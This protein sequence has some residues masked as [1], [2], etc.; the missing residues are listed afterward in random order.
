MLG[1]F[2]PGWIG[3]RWE[4]IVKR[5]QYF[6]RFAV[7][8]GV[9]GLAFAAAPPA[10]ASGWQISISP[11][12]GL[13]D[14]QLVL[15][16]GTGFTEHP[17]TQFVVDWAITE[18]N[19]TVLSQPLDPQLV[20]N[21]CDVTTE[22]FVFVHADAAG[23]VSGTFRVSTTFTPLGGGAVPVD[24]TQTQ[25]ALII[26][27]LTDAGFVGAAAP[28][29]FAPAPTCPRGDRGGHGYGDKNHCHRFRGRSTPT[30]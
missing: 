12:T 14:G 22:P 11:S 24:C 21:N 30:Q 29:S 19:S 1:W 25:C 9:V 15:V 3:M 17:N 20:I 5:R 26:A 8:W 18:C 4:A 27:Q 2:P 13:T 28:I 10:G 6:R 16:T 23:N 7:V